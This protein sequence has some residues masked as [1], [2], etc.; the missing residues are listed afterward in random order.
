MNIEDTVASILSAALETS[1][2]PDAG[3]VRENTPS[4]DSLKHVEI[5][6]MIES[7]CGISVPQEAFGNLVSQQAIVD[8]VRHAQA[9]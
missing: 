2:A 7:E 8:Y 4:W 3:L 9:A 1:V 6:F 5:I